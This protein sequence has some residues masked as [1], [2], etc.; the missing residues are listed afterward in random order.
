MCCLENR[1]RR[2]VIDNWDSWPG[3]LVGA[4]LMSILFAYLTSG[5]I[6]DVSDGA[7]YR[8]VVLKRSWR[9]WWERLSL[10]P[11]KAK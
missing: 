5:A 3:V 11:L 9:C 6:F 4:H 1:H 2:S 10:V 7:R 8:W